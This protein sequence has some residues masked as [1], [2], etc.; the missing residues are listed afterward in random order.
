MKKTN[1]R[2]K[3]SDSYKNAQELVQFYNHKR[4]TIGSNEC[5]LHDFRLHSHAPERIQEHYTLHFVLRGKGTYRLAG[6]SFACRE[7]DV[8]VTPTNVKIDTIP[9]ENDPWKYFW[10]GFDGSSCPEICETAL[11]TIDSPVYSCG[12]CAT[13]IRNLVQSIIDFMPTVNAAMRLKGL[14]AL[15]DIFA[16][17]TRERLQNMA[18]SPSI[19]SKEYYFQQSIG[20]LEDNYTNPNFRIETICDSL[21]I[22]HSYLCRI[23]KQLSGCSISSFLLQIRMREAC[24]LL[25]TT[26]DSIEKISY[27][28]GF[29]D[30]TYF[31]KAFKKKFFMTPSQYRVSLRNKNS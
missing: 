30:Y 29:N 1:R 19:Y 20:I 18:V 24:V 13:E 26:D 11:F 28:C 23:F 31:S 8:F 14:S 17:I 16:L 9:D 4:L 6:K 25:K 22:S 3:I 15:L 27:T 12:E 10:I 7:N 21:P 2:I 5:G